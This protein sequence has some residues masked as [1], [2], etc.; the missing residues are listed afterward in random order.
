MFKIILLI[1]IKKKLTK[2]QEGNIFY[3]YSPHYNNQRNSYRPVSMT[4]NM[5]NQILDI[6]LGLLDH[7]LFLIVM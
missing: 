7:P 5:T 1:I 4:T 6:S 3:P 2:T